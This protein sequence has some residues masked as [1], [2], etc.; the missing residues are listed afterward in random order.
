MDNILRL[1][2]VFGFLPL[3]V[4][5][6]FTYSKN[7]HNRPYVFFCLYLCSITVINTVSGLM[8]MNR[9]NNL[10]F[11]HVY[12]VIEFITLIFFF[13]E[14]LNKKQRNKIDITVIVV[15]IALL[16]L[17]GFHGLDMYNLKP[18][19]PLEI[20][21]CSL[22]ILVFSAM[23]LYNSISAPLKFIYVTIG[24][25]V[26]KIVSILLFMVLNF[27]NTNGNNYRDF[28]DLLW[29]L[30]RY[31]LVVYFGLIFFEWYRNYMRMKVD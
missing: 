12:F 8:A 11:S 27:A 10:I 2:G 15:F 31:F 25:V 16:S 26:Y 13:R 9:I 6:L 22:P 4:V 30:N 7:A 21:L 1:V 28:L 14:L 23:H 3:A 19:D 29:T 5:Y 20:L 24:L 17:F 18:F